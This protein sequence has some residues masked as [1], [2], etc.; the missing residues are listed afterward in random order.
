MVVPV[1]VAAS[2][3]MVPY[4]R[5]LSGAIECIKASKPEH[6]WDMMELRLKKVRWSSTVA[7]AG[8]RSPCPNL[9]VPN[10]QHPEKPGL[11]GARCPCQQ[12]QSQGILFE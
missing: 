1:V 3:L 4:L 5:L 11:E 6:C 7:A 10:P 9:V 12:Q 8:R 2:G